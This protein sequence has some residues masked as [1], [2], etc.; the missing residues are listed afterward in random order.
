[1]VENKYSI[2]INENKN[3]KRVEKPTTVCIFGYIF[4]FLIKNEPN[5]VS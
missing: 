2:F 3:M 5:E 1:M 4:Y